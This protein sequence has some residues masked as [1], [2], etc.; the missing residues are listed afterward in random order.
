VAGNTVRQI[1]SGSPNLTYD[2]INV[3][4]AGAKL[5]GSDGAVFENGGADNLVFRNGSIGGVVDQKGALVDGSNI[6]IEN[7]R[8]HD[9][10]LATSGV[11]TECL[12][13]IVTPGLTL[14]NNT[15]TNCAIMDILFEYGSWWT[16]L[17]TPY[18]NVTIEGSTFGPAVDTPNG[19]SLYIGHTGDN[20]SPG[21]LF[22]WKVRNN[23]FQQGT[24]VQPVDDGNNVFCGNTG[25]VSASWK[26]SC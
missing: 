22:G 13:A 9:V 26:T 12:Y 3:D 19:I 20:P 14:R 15:F 4:A 25:S 17:P 11:H 5:T 21:H 23:S 7:T 6:L 2:G 18:G 16:P 10:H 8:F 24:A 1:H